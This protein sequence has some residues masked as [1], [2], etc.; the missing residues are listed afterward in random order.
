MLTEPVE[1]LLDPDTPG[2]E[3]GA[4]ELL[5]PSKKTGTVALLVGSE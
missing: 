2:L 1:A 5:S 4:P 3:T